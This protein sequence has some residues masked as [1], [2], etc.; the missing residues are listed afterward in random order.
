MHR[1]APSRNPCADRAGHFAHPEPR[2][3]A[4]RAFAVRRQH[5][6]QSLPQP[7]R[8]K[9]EGGA[10]A[11]REAGFAFAVKADQAPAGNRRRESIFIRSTKASFAPES[12]RNADWPSRNTQGSFSEPF[13]KLGMSNTITG[14]PFFLNYR[15][16]IYRYW[17][18]MA[19]A[20]KNR[21]FPLAELRFLLLIYN[22]KFHNWR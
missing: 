18:K 3:P 20:Y 11:V 12:L 13:L 21:H 5:S 2:F 10:E 19:L 4:P 7:R 16:Q 15:H 1:F 6:R 17:S 22:K 14:I 8:S 9:Q